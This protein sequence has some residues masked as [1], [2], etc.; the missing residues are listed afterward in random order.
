MKKKLVLLFFA[1]LLVVLVTV[2]CAGNSVTP[3]SSVS[4][5]ASST[6]A[7]PASPTS[8]SSASGSSPTQAASSFD[9]PTLLQQSCTGCHS[10][11]RVTNSHFTADQWGQVVDQ[12]IGMGASLTTDE[13]NFLVNYLAQTYK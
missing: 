1:C 13:R 10:L 4:A 2:Q 7:A 6:A 3:T 11:D 12:M 9:G 8:S 5:P